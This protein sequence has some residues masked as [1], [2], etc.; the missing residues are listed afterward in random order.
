LTVADPATRALEAAAPSV[1][2]S[3]DAISPSPAP[4]LRWDATVDLAIV[5]GGFTGLW[6]AI[7]AADEDP[8][9]SIAI[10]E[11]HRVGFGASSRN[12]GFVESSVTHGLGNGIAHWPDE[13]DTLLRLG[14]Q[15]F[16]ELIEFLADEDADVG[17]E[18]TGAIHVATR[19]W[20]MDDLTELAGSMGEHGIRCE[21][22]DAEAMQAEVRSPTY[23]GG[24]VD[25]DGTAIVDPARLV[26]ALRSSAERRGVLIFEDSAAVDIEPSGGRLLVRTSV[27]TLTADKVMVATNAF[28]RPT[29]RMR[30]YVVPVYD[31]VLMTEPL[32]RD[33]LDSIGWKGR[34]ALA[35]V[36]NQFH[37]YRLTADDRI[38]WGGYD[39]VYRFGGPIHPGLDQAGTTHRTLAEHFFATFPQLEDVVFT[40]RWAGPIGTTSRFTATW[41]SE[42]GGKLV[43]VGGYTGL[44]V[45]ASRFGAR[46]A[47]DLL[48]GVDSERTGLA[49]VRKRP[50]PFPPE[51]LRYVGIQLTRRALARAD[52]REGQR[53]LWLRI[54]DAFGIGFDS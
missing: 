9:R 4:Q 24:L 40:H 16:A 39:A 25:P 38:L 1:F 19:P 32:S 36:S 35:D 51:P 29:T 18:V 53:G 49:M 47:L 5:G 15:N 54:L 10:L 31:Y 14:D 50:M 17:L 37:Y 7:Q 13:V 6:A 3:D 34:Q 2:W 33:Q 46:V 41:G 20:H 11:A 45:A 26:W 21:T 12:G 43:W 8:G 22:L 42:H 30:R 23:V 44:G 52:E 28:A 27:G 48:D